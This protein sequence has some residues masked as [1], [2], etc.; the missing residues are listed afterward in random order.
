MMQW[1]GRLAVATL[2]ALAWLPTSMAVLLAGVLAR[3]ASGLRL[4]PWQVTRANIEHC[5][6]EL[7][8]PAQRRLVIDSLREDVLGGI[9]IARTWIRPDT[10]LNRV[11]TS[12]GEHQRLDAAVAAGKPVVILAPHLGSWEIANFWLGQRYDFHALY[13]PSPIPALDDLIRDARQHFGSTLYPA[14]SRGVA[15]LV[16]AVRKGGVTAILPDQVAAKGG[17]R[18]APFFG[19]PAWTPTLPCRLISQSGAQAFLIFVRR[20]PGFRYEIILRD[21][22]PEIHDGDID[23]SLAALNRSVEALVREEPGQYNWSYKRFRMQEPNIY[24]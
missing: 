22:D 11:I 9:D 16:R 10:A 20:L 1:R 13:K 4:A 15:G 24:R 8:R 6:P 12:R 14:T 3:L 18:T 17:G 23:V 19:L 7:D 2:R 21:P 5:F